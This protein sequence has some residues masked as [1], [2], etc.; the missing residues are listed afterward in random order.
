MVRQ[1]ARVC[2]LEGFAI[3]AELSHLSLQSGSF[4]PQP[5]GGATGTAEDALG[6]AKDLQDVL[7]FPVFE[8]DC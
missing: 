4:Q 8:R 3:D 2:A 6:F 5:G 1:A 7:A